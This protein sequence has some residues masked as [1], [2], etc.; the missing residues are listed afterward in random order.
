MKIVENLP[1]GYG[2]VSFG[3]IPRSHMAGSLGITIS[4]FVRKQHIDC[5]TIS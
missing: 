2:G 1:L 4:N 3:L 5:Q